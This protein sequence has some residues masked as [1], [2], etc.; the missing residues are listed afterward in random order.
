MNYLFSNHNYDLKLKIKNLTYKL[1]TRNSTG[2]PLPSKMPIPKLQRL[3]RDQQ[4][5]G[6]STFGSELLLKL[7]K[8][9]SPNYPSM[10]R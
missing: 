10:A 4:A 9:S 3:Y 7:P 2:Y 5:G 1:G 8:E 6:R